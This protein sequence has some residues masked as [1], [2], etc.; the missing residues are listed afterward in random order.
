MSPNYPFF[1]WATI[2]AIGFAAEVF[3]EENDAIVLAIKNPNLAA[4]ALSRGY[5]CTGSVYVIRNLFPCPRGT[6][7]DR[8][9]KHLINLHE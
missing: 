3:A 8:A 7:G 1:T 9:G 4:S 5:H 2:I 6:A